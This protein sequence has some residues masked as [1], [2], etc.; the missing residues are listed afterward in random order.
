[1]D[2]N[3]DKTWKLMPSLVPTPLIRRSVYRAL[4]RNARWRRIRQHARESSGG[5][6]DICGAPERRGM[7]CH[8]D[9]LY[10]DETHIA[11]L[12]RFRWI[13]P[14]CNAV[15][16]LGEGPRSWTGGI[17]N[18]PARYV[19]DHMIEVNGMT[20]DEASAVLVQANDI[21]D[22]RSVHDWSLRISDDV[23]ERYPFLDALTL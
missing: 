7:I 10:D 3:I 16:H 9:W 18:D 13:C 23:L 20:A 4:G 12:T 1:M 6:C 21:W 22:E 17:E 14:D 2:P 19:F 11:L 8:E 15:I 5:S